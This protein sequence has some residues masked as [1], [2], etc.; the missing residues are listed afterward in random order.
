MVVVAI[1]LFA[2]EV[3][4]SNECSRSGRDRWT[5]YIFRGHEL[6]LLFTVMAGYESFGGKKKML[7]RI[8]DTIKRPA[9]LA[10]SAPTVFA[11]RIEQHSSRYSTLDNVQL[12]DQVTYVF[13]V[14]VGSRFIETCSF[15]FVRN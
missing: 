2:R 11:K 1:E 14:R 3:L 7:K 15:P 12:P 13:F 10:R 9:I 4:Y 8:S 5:K 6:N